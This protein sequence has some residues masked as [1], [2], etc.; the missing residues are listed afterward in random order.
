MAMAL[1]LLCMLAAGCRFL[2]WHWSLPGLVADGVLTSTPLTTWKSVLE[3]SFMLSRGLSPYC[4]SMTTYSSQSYDVTDDV[5]SGGDFGVITTS[6]GSIH[7]SPLLLWPL[8][9]LYDSVA[10]WIIV[11]LYILVDVVCA[12]LLANVVALESDV[13]ERATERKQCTERARE[14]EHS[15]ESAE[16]SKEKVMEREISTERVKERQKG[17]EKLE[18][19]KTCSTPQG[20]ECASGKQSWLVMTL[21]L[22]S[23]FSVLSCAGLTTSTLH[24]VPL[25]VLLYSASTGRWHTC[26]VS[27][28]ISCY[29]DVY[30][31]AMLAPLLAM[32]ATSRFSRV[33]FVV[34]FTCTLLVLLILSAYISCGWTFLHAVYRPIFM[35]SDLTPNIGL[36][37]YFFAEMF[38]HFEALFL[39][40]FQINSFIYAV[41]LTLRFRDRPFLV[42]FS[43]LLLQS[44][45]RPYPNGCDVAIYTALLPLWRPLAAHLRYSFLV[46]VSSVCTIVLAPVMWA[47]W[48]HAGSANANFFFAVTLAFNCTQI[49]LVADIL[50]AASKQAFERVHGTSRTIDGKPARLLLM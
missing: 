21:Y 8:V 13:V 35:V 23:P 6:C 28:A 34:E 42:L 47:L 15:T 46:A 10:I 20:S 12:V 40:A 41:P 18:E 2:A 38:Q 33:R 48:I 39:A 32:T 22:F 3:G 1:L 11:A 24:S 26:A 5:S 31:A 36:F 17:T 37:W 49:Y 29:L 14:Q 30:P 9:W 27:L 19:R 4:Q 16:D 7:Q 25:V 50:F 45:F 43:L 44:V